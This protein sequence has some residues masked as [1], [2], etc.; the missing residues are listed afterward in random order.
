MKRKGVFW[1]HLAIC[2]LPA[3]PSPPPLHPEPA[4]KSERRKRKEIERK[5]GRKSTLAVPEPSLPHSP[6]DR[7]HVGHPGTFAVGEVLRHRGGPGAVGRRPAAAMD[8]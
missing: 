8:F 7:R 1:V 4:A 5:K 6:S 2:L 3:S